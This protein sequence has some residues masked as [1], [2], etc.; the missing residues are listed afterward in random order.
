MSLGVLG[1]HSV[2]RSSSSHRMR[3]TSA[4]PVRPCHPRRPRQTGGLPAAHSP[5]AAAT[6]QLGLRTCACKP[7]TVLRD[8]P[9]PLPSAGGGRQSC[10]ERASWWEGVHW[11]DATVLGG[12]ARMAQA[13]SPQADKQAGGCSGSAQ[14]GKCP[15]LAAGRLKT[16]K[17]RDEYTGERPVRRELRRVHARTRHAR[18]A[19]EA[20][21]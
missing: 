14:S 12:S 1:V 4:H 16:I 2:G 6:L 13:S 11:R 9:G 3:R 17:T 18:Q 7:G 15:M 8:S 19:R 20:P 5:P 10:S 21:K